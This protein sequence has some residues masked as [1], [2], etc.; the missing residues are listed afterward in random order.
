[1]SS[2]SCGV[3]QKNFANVYRLQRHMISHDESAGLRKFKCTYCD[4]AFK[5]KHHLK[6]RK[7]DAAAAKRAIKLINSSVSRTHTQQEHV[8]IHSGE[9]PFECANCGKR[10]S[11]SGSYSSH[12]TSKKC[13]ILNSRVSEQ[14]KRKRKKKNRT[15]SSCDAQWSVFFSFFLH[16][17]RRATHR[18]DIHFASIDLFIWFAAEQPAE[19]SGQPRQDGSDG[20]L[21]RLLGRTAG[22]PAQ[23]RAPQLDAHDGDG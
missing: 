22:E 9:K 10:F 4:K 8:R 14:L 7:R 11:H 2:Q 17:H 23:H 6:V 12:M 21:V 5:F 1:M 20:R 18:R 15:Y 16:G 3:C 13:L 19:A